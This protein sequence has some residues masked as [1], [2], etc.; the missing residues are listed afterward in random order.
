MGLKFIA[1]LLFIQELFINLFENIFLLF[2]SFIIILKS[3]LIS[4]VGGF[5][6]YMLKRKKTGEKF[7]FKKSFFHCFIAGFTGIL[8]QKLCA[9]FEINQ[10][11]TSFLVGISGF[12][13]T[14]ML[15]FFE[16][17]SKSIFEKIS[18]LQIEVKFGKNKNE[19]N[20]NEN[21]DESKE[22]KN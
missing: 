5:A 20:N 15:V 3:I 6:D 9:G 14:R 18:E 13:G 17:L 2:G 1:L 21:D 16:K 8:A 7:S 10:E 4:L 22:S 12:A 11:L 19:N